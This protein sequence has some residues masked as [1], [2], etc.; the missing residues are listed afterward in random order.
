M[1]DEGCEV[2]R[3]ATIPL[4]NVPLHPD[5]VAREGEGAANIRVQRTHEED[6][7][8]ILHPAELVAPEAVRTGSGWQRI[9]GEVP[10]A[11]IRSNV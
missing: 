6:V 4:H 1:T 8:L 3:G 7:P 9:A 11:G 5:L 2:P 10:V